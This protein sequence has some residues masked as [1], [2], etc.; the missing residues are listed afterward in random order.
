MAHLQIPVPAQL[1]MTCVIAGSRHIGPSSFCQGLHK[2]NALGV[3]T[4]IAAVQQD[5]GVRRKRGADRRHF[6]GVL[7]RYRLG[8]ERGRA[9]GNLTR[10]TMAENVQG[11]HRLLLRR[12]YGGKLL[13]A[14]TLTIKDEDLSREILCVRLDILHGS[15]YDQDLIGNGGGTSVHLLG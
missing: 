15:I 11:C 14:V 10:H 5:V 12:Q 3:I 1:C 7:C 6:I 13:H 2:R 4:H 9:Q 8:T